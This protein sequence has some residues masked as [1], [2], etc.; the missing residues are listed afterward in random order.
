M[1]HSE[2]TKHGFFLKRLYGNRNAE[3]H[4]A[5][6]QVLVLHDLLYNLQSIRTRDLPSQPT[7]LPP[8]VPHHAGDDWAVFVGFTQH[9]STNTDLCA[10]PLLYESTELAWNL[11][12][13]RMLRRSDQL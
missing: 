2:S 11:C 12:A 4:S 1:V 6:R 13:A 9:Q 3:S 10:V 8:R 5:K 7:E